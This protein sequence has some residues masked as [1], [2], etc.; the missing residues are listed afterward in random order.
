MY[1]TEG[2]CRVSTGFNKFKTFYFIEFKRC[3][4]RNVRPCNSGKKNK[5]P[6]LLSAVRLSEVAGVIA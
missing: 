6:N 3:D 2:L 5:K 4:H 1:S